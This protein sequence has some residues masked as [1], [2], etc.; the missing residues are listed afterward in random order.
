MLRRSPLIALALLASACGE[1]GGNPFAASLPSRPPSANAAL[2]FVSGSWS[3]EGGQP[4]ELMAIAADGSGLQQLTN[5]AR[6]AQPCDILQVSPSPDRNRMI[7]VRT[8]PDAAAGANVMYF[9]DL[10]RSVEQVLLPKRRVESADWSFDGSFL[11]YSSVTGQTGNED[12]FTAGPDGANEQNLTDSLNV[13]ERSGRIDPFGRTAVFERLDVD[14]VSHIYLFRESPLTSGP[15]TGP[16]LPGTPY[17][18]GSDAT[19]AFSPDSSQV[20]FRRLT[21][22]GNGGLGTWDVMAIPVTA[23]ATPRTVVTGPL[24]R[25]AADWSLGGIVYVETDAAA[26]RSELVVIQPDGSGRKV[27]RTEAASFRMGAPRWLP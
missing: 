2:I 20:V 9:M 15:A 3:N 6:A 21:G 27:L 18:V 23:N 26:N 13:R 14:G 19:P 4:R 22:V 10:S 7:A 12:L 5:C 17:L 1:S 25:S 8:T 11:L 16:G 24:Y